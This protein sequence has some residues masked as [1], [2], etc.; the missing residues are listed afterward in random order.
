MSAILTHSSV[1]VLFQLLN[2]IRAI[3]VELIQLRLKFG[4]RN[5]L[6]NLIL[7]LHCCGNKL[8]MSAF[9]VIL[10]QNPYS[11]YRI[12]YRHRPSFLRFKSGDL[13]NLKL[14]NYRT[15]EQV[16][17]SFY[18]WKEKLKMRSCTTA[19]IFVSFEVRCS[20]TQVDRYWGMFYKYIQSCSY[21]EADLPSSKAFT[22]YGVFKL[23]RSEHACKSGRT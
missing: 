19:N 22:S 23:W 3:A 16:F 18:R 7:S 13:G 5:S 17:G 8:F 20:L 12:N 15:S 6:H 14:Y 21:K 9:K 2:F 1:A 4:I 10:S 11:Q